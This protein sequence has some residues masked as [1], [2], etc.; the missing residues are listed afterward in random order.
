MMSNAKYK[1]LVVEDELLVAMDIEESLTNLGYIVQNTVDT[2]ILAIE[3][4]EKSLPDIILMDINLKG[5]MSGIDAAKVICSKND[6]PVVYLTANADLSTINQAKVALPYG[7]IIKPFVDKDLQTNIEIAIF[8]FKSDMKF[9]LESEQ[10]NTFFDLKDHDNNQLIIHAQAGLEKINIDK[11]FFLEEQGDNTILHM[12][13]E[14]IIVEKSLKVT[15]DLFPKADFVQISK[16]FIIN[17]SKVFIVKFPEVI[18]S[19]KMSVITV[20]PEF[21]ANLDSITAEMDV[22]MDEN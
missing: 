4:V 2:G 8:K 19:E 14:E 18:I 12:L 9:K 1:V 20:D 21:R 6:V 15:Y 7:Y 10:F 17:S 5:D 11:V 3:E 22:T 13:D 16:Q